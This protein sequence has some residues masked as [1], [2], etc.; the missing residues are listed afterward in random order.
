ML[1]AVNDDERLSLYCEAL[2]AD[3]R[4]TMLRMLNMQRPLEM[5][6]VSAQLRLYKEP[7]QSYDSPVSDEE[8]DDINVWIE[9]ERQRRERHIKEIYDPEKAIRTFHRC[10]IIGDPGAGKTTLLRHLAVMAAQSSISGM[11]SLLPIYVELQSFVHSGLHDLLDFVSTTWEEEYAFPPRQARLL[12]TKLLDEGKALLLLDALDETV[13]G[14][15]PESAEQ[16]Y[17]AVSQ[18]ILNLAADYPKAAIVVTIRKASYSQHKPL[19]NFTTLEMMDF[20]FEDV[21]QL[22]RSWYDAADDVHAEEKSSDL[23]SL[24]DAHPR[25]LTLAA[26][27]LLLTLI[28]LAY[29]DQLDLPVR[30]AEL[31]R[32]CIEAVLTRWDAQRGV[33][34][35]EFEPERKH[36]LLKA[37]A[38]HFH[39]KRQRYFTEH[40]LLKVIAEFLPAVGLPAERNK[41]ILQE[42]ESEEGV[43][44]EQ[45]TGWHGFEHLTLQEYFAAEYINDHQE[46]AKLLRHRADPWWEEVLLLYVGITP[47]ASLFLQEL[48]SQNSTIREDIFFTRLLLAGRCLAARPTVRK[49]GLQGQIIERLFELFMS[50]QH[51]LLRQEAL[52]VLC[53]I[54]VFET[55]RRLLKL[56]LDEQVNMFMRR[57]ITG[58]LGTVGEPSVASDLV[59]LLSDER[60]DVHQRWSITDALGRLGERSVA[61]DLV[62]LLADEQLDVNLRWSI[63]T[64]LSR[65]GER[66]VAN[67][68]ARLLADDRLDVDLRVSIADA[69][70]TLGER[71][72]AGDLVQLLA[73]DGL[74]V[75]LR[76]SIAD[77]LGTLGDRSVAG[78][79]VQLLADDGLDV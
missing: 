3:P 38:W 72:V 19:A 8:E 12:L 6:W 51:S 45:A 33:G 67:D 7:Q 48:C 71:S 41:A 68:L 52:K 22:V 5:A 46:Y 56:L 39:R 40:D 74:D 13:M 77:A 70:G 18:T 61:D 50:T 4:L 17:E 26:N 64:A 60:L 25:L 44:K 57:R 42:I 1:G 58:A 69:L 79:L 34:R 59:L 27:P 2:L 54:G 78:D 9:E 29:E 47:D 55:T 66:S 15:T 43:L 35:Q 62:Q 16:S 23:I 30:R 37:I 11:T 20:R 49:I 63:V 10:V 32:V 53:G 36:Q 76:V 28:V 73:D 21:K 75:E 14:E 31:Y 65:L 24:L